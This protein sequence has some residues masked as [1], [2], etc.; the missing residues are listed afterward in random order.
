MKEGINFRITQLACDDDARRI[1]DFTA[2]KARRVKDI[3]EACHIPL[4]KCYRR[5]KEMELQGMLRRTEDRATK[6]TMYATNLR[7]LQMMIEDEK[8]SLNIEFRD[9][10]KRVF[11]FDAAAYG[12]MAT[13]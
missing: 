6:I 8:L 4:A 2:S 11:E 3:A 1:L 7:S 12:S 10:T 5:V 9:G 13:A